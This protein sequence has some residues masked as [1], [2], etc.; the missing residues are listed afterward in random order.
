MSFSRKVVCPYCAAVNRIPAERLNDNPHCGK[1]KKDIFAL[2]PVDLTAATFHS[3]VVNSEIPV[4]VDFWAEWCGPCK[5]M[6][7][8]FEK[9]AAALEP[10]V[11]LA[12]LNTENEQ[13]IAAQFDIRSIPTMILFK[14]GKEVARQS[15]AMMGGQIEQWVKTQLVALA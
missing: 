11:R 5:M 12:K 8:A 7:P 15:G 1:C 9:A 3:Q 4:L 14:D 2:K 10:D 6:A 13:Q